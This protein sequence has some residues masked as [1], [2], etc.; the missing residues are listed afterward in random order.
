[1]TFKKR[2]D[3]DIS[4]AAGVIGSCCIGEVFPLEKI[5]DEM[6]PSRFVGEGFCIIPSDNKFVCPARG[7]V[8]DVSES[9]LDVTI[10]T[11]DG[12][13]LIV[14][15]G[16]EGGSRLD[17]EVCVQRGDI[18]S[19]ENELWK[20]DINDGSLVSVTVVTNCYG[21]EFDVRYGKVKQLGQTVMTVDL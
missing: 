2:A 9:G 5:S 8:K 18:V 7:E 19:S 15:L 14:S 6:F 12:L 4:T 16:R 10:K 17:A 1:M 13:L 3:K 11:T 21:K 20:T